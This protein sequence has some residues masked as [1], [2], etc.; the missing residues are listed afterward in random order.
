M[1]TY[2]ANESIMYVLLDCNND[3]DLRRQYNL[4]RH[5]IYVRKAN[6][7]LTLLLKIEYLLTV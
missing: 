7:Y 1:F 3:I 4:D 6:L 2:F 5:F